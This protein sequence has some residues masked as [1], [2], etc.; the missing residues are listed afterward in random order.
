[1]TKVSNNDLDC[2]ITGLPCP[3]TE[4]SIEASDQVKALPRPMPAIGDT[5]RIKFGAACRIPLPK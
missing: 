4:A 3:D 1:M 5:G 2:D